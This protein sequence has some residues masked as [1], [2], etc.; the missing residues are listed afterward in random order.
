ML[1]SFV[2]GYFV[3]FGAVHVVSSCF[4]LIYFLKL[5]SGCPSSRK[6]VLLVLADFTLF[7]MDGS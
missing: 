3:E 5:V 2:L 6:V 7:L 4:W 1:F